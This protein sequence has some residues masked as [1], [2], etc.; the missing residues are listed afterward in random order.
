MFKN[1][2]LFLVL[3]TVFLLLSAASLA[4]PQQMNFQGRLTS[5]GGSPVTGQKTVYFRLFNDPFAGAQVGGTIT[6]TVSCDSIG[7]F[8]TMLD[9]GSSYFD[10]SDRWLEIEIQGDS[11][12]L[13]PR[14]IIAVV[15]Y[16]YRALTA[17]SVVGGGGGGGDYVSKTGDTM[18]GKLT[19]ITTPE[20]VCL[21]VIGSAEVGSTANSARGQYAIALGNGTTASGKYSTAMGY[22]T[23]ATADY[24]TAMGYMS[25]AEGI[26]SVALGYNAKAKANYSIAM[27]WGS[28]SNGPNCVTMGN[29]TYASNNSS[30][31]MGQYTTASGLNSFAMG[32]QTTAGGDSSVAMGN[33]TTANGNYSTA[34]GRGIIVNGT[35]SFGIGLDSTSRT[36][37]PNNTLAIMGGKV[38]IATA[39][40]AVAL[41][42]NG[43]ILGALPLTDVDFAWHSQNDTGY[44]AIIA[45]GVPS[46]GKVYVRGTPAMSGVDLV[47]PVAW[48]GWLDLGAP[49]PSARLVSVSCSF[50]GM[51]NSPSYRGALVVARTSSGKVWLKRFWTIDGGQLNNTGYWSGWADFGGPGL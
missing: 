20:T 22:Y 36:L 5:A 4:I 12:P 18:T 27:G 37:T 50:D 13:S 44:T 39:E 21:K 24:A 10:G 42:V 45:A 33:V 30:L 19:I 26:A 46:T 49:E 40:P 3:A 11:S 35:N 38:G 9:L 6:K 28:T 34:L 51:N 1:I 23:G 47:N 31:A 16:A 41:E 25:S 2:K 43:T 14:Q 8:S 15:P 7:A 29:L 17:E 48:Y 32:F